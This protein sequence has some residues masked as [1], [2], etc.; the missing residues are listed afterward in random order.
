MTPF[1]IMHL[2]NKKYGKRKEA[3]KLMQNN[4]LDGKTKKGLFCDFSFVQKLE[5]DISSAVDG[6]PFKHAKAGMALID[7]NENLTPEQKAQEKM[8]FAREAAARTAIELDIGTFLFGTWRN[9]LGVYSLD[10]NI[11]E[12]ALASLIPDETPSLIFSK[13]PEWCIYME[14]PESSDFYISQ[15][16]R[17]TSS[18]TPAGS[19]N[20]STDVKVL[21]FWAMHDKT[22]QNKRNTAVGHDE[23]LSLVITLHLDF[24]EEHIENNLVT[25]P[26]YL[27]LRNN[28]TINEAINNEYGAYGHNQKDGGELKDIFSVVLS[29]LLW[30]CVE[31]PDVSNAKGEVLSR[32]D[33]LKPKY[34]RNKKT[35]AF[36]PPD[37][38]KHYEIG[39]RLGGEI[40]DYNAK[41][42]VA[43]NMSG[44]RKKPHIRKG[45]WHGVWR[46]V[47]D[48]REFDTYWQS[49]IFV[50][51]KK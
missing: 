48:E 4:Y 17:E 24:P 45:H 6:M 16:S 34:G 2:F 9:T 14:L 12:Q 37:A 28:L 40:R 22:K 36:I 35:G 1:Q 18:D 21:G 11:S 41:V 27:P 31:E 43:S 51:S 10:K 33:M 5:Q 50:N 46:G 7:E 19:E 39:K 15:S 29:L 13:L 38:I 42:D 44:K 23:N 26:L 25:T 20:T 49:T 3:Y 8:R 47:G 30:L 32:E